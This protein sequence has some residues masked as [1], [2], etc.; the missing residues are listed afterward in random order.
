MTGC[1]EYTGNR[2][3]HGGM[4]I[5]KRGMRRATA[6]F[7][8]CFAL[9][10]QSTV[11][12]SVSVSSPICPTSFG[13]AEVSSPTPSQTNP[14]NHPAMVDSTD[15]L[16]HQGPICTPASTI[17]STYPALSPPLI[18]SF[19]EKAEDAGIASLSLT[20]IWRPPTRI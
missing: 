15:Q 5:A 16:C 20:V 13:S 7:L 9:L 14:C 19:H 4:V 17:V 2:V 12:A 11:S 1:S 3:G 8:L 18:K 6:T 10:F